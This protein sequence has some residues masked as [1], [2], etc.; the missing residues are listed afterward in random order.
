MKWCLSS[1]QSYEYLKKADEI[2]VP[3]D[4]RYNI[5]DYIETNPKARIVIRLS[6]EKMLFEDDYN[7]LKDQLVIC[8][9]N[10][11]VIVVDDKQAQICNK[12]EIPFFFAYP[13]RTF[14]QLRRMEIL[15]ACDA[16]ID[17]VLAHSLDQ[18]KDYHSITI[19]V[20][21]NSC[22]WGAIP[23]IWNNIEGSWFRPEDLWKM[24]QIDVAEFR[25][26]LDAASHLNIEIQKQEQ[27]LYKLYAERHEWPGKVDEFVF[28]IG[29]LG[30]LNRLLPE[31][32]QERRSNCKM[33]CM[34]NGRCHFCRFH[35]DLATK[36]K[37]VV[38][39]KNLEEMRNE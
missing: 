4:D 19:R 2:S 5:L 17:D 28:D 31:D 36:D 20:F 6:F 7:W 23:G 8:K 26:S 9:N 35:C 38:I 22:G 18:I 33:K 30:I 11:A 12:L 34:E 14:N 16:Y 27:A 15:G 10:M 1:R 24:D 32:F 29:Q 3:W 21:A 13:A 25:V 39:K 37:A